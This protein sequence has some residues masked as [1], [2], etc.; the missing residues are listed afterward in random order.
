M[1]SLLRLPRSRALAAPLLALALAVGAGLPTTARA[2]RLQD[3]VSADSFGNLVVWSRSGYKRI[4]VGQGHLANRLDA[5]VSGPRVIYGAERDGIEDDPYLEQ[6]GYLNQE[7]AGYDGRHRY[8]HG[9]YRHGCFREPAFV[10]G[11]DYMYGLAYGE[12]PVIAPC[13]GPAD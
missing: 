4:V 2:D 9:R 1:R 3:E 12:L 8:H 6:D 10:K 13:A 11:R 5:Y 7:G